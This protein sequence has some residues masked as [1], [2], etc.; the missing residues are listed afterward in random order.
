M[1]EQR[2]TEA[3]TIPIISVRNVTAGYGDEIIIQ[4]VSFDVFEG[5]IFSILGRSGCGKTTLFK[6][7]TGLLEPVEGAVLID[8][9]EICC[10]ESAQ[11]GAV[12]KKVGVTFQSGALFTSMTLAENAAFPLRLHTRLSADTIEQI[13]RLK[14]SEVGLAGFEELL[15]AELSGGMQKRAALARAMALDPKILFFDEPSAGLDPVTSAT[16]DETILKIN[17]SLGTTMVIV[18]H[19]LASILRTADR[20]IMLDREEKTIIAQGSP[21]ELR[22]KSDDPRVRDFFNRSASEP[23]LSLKR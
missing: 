3:G 18:T 4:D 20:V 15:P 2:N 7:M 6:V 1:N 23:D 8:G 21:Q 22:D 17:K 19:E 14:L 11:T 5:E 12:L 9:E 16:L 10:G 13:V